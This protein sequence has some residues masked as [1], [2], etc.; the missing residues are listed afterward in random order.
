MGVDLD[1][2]APGSGESMLMVSRSGT[3]VS[4]A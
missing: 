3:A 1:H 4:I 2:G